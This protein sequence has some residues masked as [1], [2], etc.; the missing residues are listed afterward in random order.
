M[1]SRSL[2]L[3][4]QGV[5]GTLVLSLSALPA[6]LA[7]P[8]LLTALRPLSD[9]LLPCAA[10]ARADLALC[11]ATLA[12][13]PHLQWRQ[14][15]HFADACKATPQLRSNLRALRQRLHARS[16]SHK[17]KVQ[18]RHCTCM[19]RYSNGFSLHV[20]PGNARALHYLS[21]HGFG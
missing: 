10:G 3:P 8:P 5:E 19:M 15:C 4:S 11:R 9:F 14:V 6:V 21:A 20:P 7:S 17:R 12:A 16:N 1:T 18:D 13:P 2:V